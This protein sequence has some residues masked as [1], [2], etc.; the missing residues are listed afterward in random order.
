MHLYLSKGIEIS[1]III[2]ITISWIR[3]NEIATYD[4][5]NIKWLKYRDW[6]KIGNQIRENEWDSMC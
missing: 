2:L 1:R 6:M 4:N 5:D 3:V